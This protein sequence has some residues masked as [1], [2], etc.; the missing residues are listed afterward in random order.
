M[1]RASCCLRPGDSSVGGEASPQHPTARGAPSLQTVTM[2]AQR[3]KE[4]KLLGQ[5]Q[6]PG[7]EQGSG[8]RLHA[9]PKTGWVS[10][11]G[12]DTGFCFLPRKMVLAWGQTALE[13]CFWW[14]RHHG[15][16]ACGP[17]PIRSCWEGVGLLWGI[18]SFQQVL[19]EEEFDLR[20]QGPR[21][22]WPRQTLV[23]EGT[24]GGW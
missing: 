12:P 13:G 19:S 17:T 9:V 23:G 11:S 3:M 8:L 20:A 7:Q 16:A 18:G 6:K 5:Q 15:S 2:I 22:R 21:P 10:R 24:A 14:Q 4:T 1:L